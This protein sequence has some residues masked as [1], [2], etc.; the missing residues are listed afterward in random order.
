MEG[1]IVVDEQVRTI[2]QEMERSQD[3]KLR[4]LVL[5]G[6]DLTPVAPA[7]LSRAVLGLREVRLERCEFSDE[8]ADTLVRDIAYSKPQQI[9]LKT[10]SIFKTRVLISP[11]LLRKVQERINF[12]IVTDVIEIE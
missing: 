4:K 11:P 2:F 6:V 12:Q 3:V 5:T 8:Q 9:A 1:P 10:L 7:V